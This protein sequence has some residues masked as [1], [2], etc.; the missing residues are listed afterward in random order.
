M[1]FCLRGLGDYLN[2]DCCLLMMMSAM[3]VIKLNWGIHMRTIIT[4]RHIISFQILIQN[5][6]SQKRLWRGNVLFLYMGYSIDFTLISFSFIIEGS[7]I[8]YILL[9][10]FHITLSTITAAVWTLFSLELVFFH[11]FLIQC[12]LFFLVK[13]DIF[14]W[15]IIG[16][17]FSVLWEFH[18][19]S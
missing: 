9:V 13:L 1:P 7:L 12:C 18:T 3:N 16:R 5:I 8:L 4:S 10:V 15:N 6:I 17:I 2:E 14:R 11:S 19:P